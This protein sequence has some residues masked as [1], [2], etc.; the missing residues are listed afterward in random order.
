MLTKVRCPSCGVEDLLR[1]ALTEPGPC[2]DCGTLREV[3]ERV[4][5]RRAG[6]DRRGPTRLQRA[7]DYDPRSWFDRRQA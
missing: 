3:V 2:P 4:A 7:W 6:P 1:A 5:D